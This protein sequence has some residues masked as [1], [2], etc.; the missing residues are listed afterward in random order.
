MLER[1]FPRYNV[2]SRI[3]S[4]DFRFSARSAPVGGE[5][6]A[7]LRKKAI[8][9]LRIAGDLN[10]RVYFDKSTV[11]RRSHRAKSCVI[12]TFLNGDKSSRFADKNFGV[13]LPLLPFLLPRLEARLHLIEKALRQLSTASSRQIIQLKRS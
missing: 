12:Y 3:N 11:S 6:G 7:W 2:V 10:R 9:K 5:A 13:F 4:V 1:P 8:K